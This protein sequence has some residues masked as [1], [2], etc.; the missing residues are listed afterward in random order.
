M[1]H[2][3]S[4]IDLYYFLSRLYN[5]LSENLWYR[6]EIDQFIITY[7]ALDSLI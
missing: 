5:L 6:F 7:V 2:I 4:I 1:Q 3:Y